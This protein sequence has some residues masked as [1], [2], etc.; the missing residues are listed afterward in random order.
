MEFRD[1]KK[2]YQVLKKDI[3]SVVIDAMTNANFILGNDVKE[4]EK[5]LADYVGVKH[6]VACA[7]GTDALTLAA[8][9]LDLKPGD[10]VFVPDFTFFAS[11]EIVAFEGATPV[12]VDVYKDTY[13]MSA[14]SL[15]EAI[16]AVINEGKLKPKAVIPVDLFG[17]TADY[18]KII[19]VAKKYNLKVIEDAAQGFGGT[20]NGKRAGSFGD[21]ACTSFFPAKPLGCY[22]D[23]GAVFTN[24]DNVYD[25]LI[26]VRMHGRSKDDVYN[27]LRIGINS[28]LDAIQAKILKIKLKAFKE[29]E[30][31]LVN[32][33][34]KVYDDGLKDVVTTPVIPE[35]FYSSWAQYTI[36]VENREDLATYLKENGIPTKVYYGIPMHK[37]K[38]FER[39]R[40]K[41]IDMPNNDFLHER[42]ISI[43]IGPYLSTDDQN[44]VISCIKKFY[45]K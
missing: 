23:G 3:D 34:A 8:M 12:F 14:E 20:L 2:Q 6:C 22:G 17:M 9:S 26:S 42:D 39:I 43:P 40:T 18:E 5:E 1:L 38:A 41:Y 30:L 37:Q 33:V 35:K 28:R 44:K 24:D 15:E 19:P 13:N 21:I 25:Y 31:E 29:T 16:K 45:G 32:K 10:A 27:N 4:L 11:G 7:N 36:V